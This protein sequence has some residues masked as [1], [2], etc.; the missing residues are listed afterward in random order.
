MR[1]DYGTRKFLLGSQE[2]KNKTEINNSKL[3][4]N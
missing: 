1:N 4:V 3:G 2:E